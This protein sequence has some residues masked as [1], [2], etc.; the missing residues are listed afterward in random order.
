MHKYCHIIQYAGFWLSRS[1]LYFYDK[2]YHSRAAL[3]KGY[4]YQRTHSLGI[5][6][7]M[8]KPHRQVKDIIQSG[9]ALTHFEKHKWEKY[10]K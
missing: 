6:D 4:D 3:L 10:P 7:H 9:S 5:S 1:P 8:I 2:L